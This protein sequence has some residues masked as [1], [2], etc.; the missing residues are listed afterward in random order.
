ME[1]LDISPEEISDRSQQAFL[2]AKI[3]MADPEKL[4]STLNAG[5]PTVRDILAA[6]A[7]P[8]ATSATTCPSPSPGKAS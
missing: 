5:L 4:A 7:A 1:K 3:K 2:Q 8:A 6:L